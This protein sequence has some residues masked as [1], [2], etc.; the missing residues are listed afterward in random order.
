VGD[1]TI[2]KPQSTQDNTNPEAKRTYSRAAG[3]IS[4]YDPRVQFAEEALSVASP[5][6]NA[7]FV[8]YIIMFSSKDVA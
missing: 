1:R 8:W 3:G 6:H 7:V 5:E 4:T 2:A